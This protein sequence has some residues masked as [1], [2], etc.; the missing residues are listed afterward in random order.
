MS[1]NHRQKTLH[2]LTETSELKNKVNDVFIIE[3]GFPHSEQNFLSFSHILVKMLR[4]DIVMCRLAVAEV[5]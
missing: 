4:P 2:I 5:S 1:K 3:Y